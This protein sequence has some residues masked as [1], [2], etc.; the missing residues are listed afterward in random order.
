MPP[1]LEVDIELWAVWKKCFQWGNETLLFN[2]NKDLG[3]NC[4][5]HG[6]SL[7]KKV[8]QKTNK[9]SLPFKSF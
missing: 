1:K 9:S 7:K 3:E 2:G 4:Y 5:I 8:F 6:H